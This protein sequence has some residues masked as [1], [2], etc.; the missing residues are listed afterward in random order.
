MMVL[1]L[2]AMINPFISPALEEMK[3][4]SQVELSVCCL[5]I[6]VLAM[7]LSLYINVD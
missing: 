6:I 3:K 7:P 5:I 2:Y 1:D 4:S